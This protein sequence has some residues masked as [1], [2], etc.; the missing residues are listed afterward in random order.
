M[1]R[2]PNLKQGYIFNFDVRDFKRAGWFL[3]WKQNTG[4][5]AC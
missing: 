4:Q 2:N 1:Y 5:I 3:Y